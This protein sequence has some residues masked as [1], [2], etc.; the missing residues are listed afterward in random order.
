M[1]LKVELRKVSAI[2]P[3]DNNPRRNEAA[4]PGVKESIRQFGFKQPIVVD[5]NGVIVVGHTRF[6]AA[7]ELGMKTVPVVVA[8]DLTADQIKAYRIIDNK[9]NEKA[10]WD[11]GLL[12]L[13]LNDIEMDLGAFD[14]KFDFVVDA[15]TDF[16]DSTE[17]TKKK[18]SDDLQSREVDED[19][20]DDKL[21]TY[22]NGTIR[23]IVLYFDV[24][25]YEKAVKQLEALCEEQKCL[26]NTDAV[27]WLLDEYENNRNNSQGD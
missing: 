9:T 13:E 20:T 8:D 16:S 10:E 2:S 17:A 15:T 12:N 22:L 24:P 25:G 1:Q 21:D 26:S 18:A 19:R 7:L 5:E 3:Y 14:V 27:M 4:I 23:Q 6:R 11:I